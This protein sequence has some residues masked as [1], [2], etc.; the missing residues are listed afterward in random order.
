[1]VGTNQQ[2]AGATPRTPAH[3][4]T[5]PRHWARVDGWGMAVQSLGYLHQPATVDE[6]RDVFRIARETGK[7]VALRG[8]GRSYGDASIGDDSIV[9]DVSR[10]NRILAWDPATGIVDAEPGVTLEI[11]WRRIITDGWWPAV[12]SGTMYTTMAG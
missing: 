11:L 5:G 1:M 8:G 2:D 4:G 12:V 9:L 10:M 6:I 3:P 7:P